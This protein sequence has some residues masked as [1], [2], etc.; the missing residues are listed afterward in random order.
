MKTIALFL[1]LILLLAF[2]SMNVGA[3]SVGFQ[4][5]IMY[6]KGQALEPSVKYILS[7]L[8]L[9]RTIALIAVGLSL[10][11]CGVLLQTILENS[12]AEPYTLG[13]SGGAALGAVVAFIFSTSLGLPLGAFFGAFLVTGIVLF[14]TKLSGSW[15]SNVLILVGVMVSLFCGSLVTILVSVL[16]PSKMQIVLFWMMGQ[17]GS[18]RDTW[19]PYLVLLFAI[20]YLFVFFKRDQLDRLLLGDEQASSLGI[21][22]NKLKIEVIVCVCLLTA[23]SVSI[24]GLIGFVGLVAPHLSYLLLKTRRHRLTLTAAPLVGAAMFLM[25]DVVVR[26]FSRDIEFPSGGVMSL[27]GAPLLVYLL[28]R[29]SRHA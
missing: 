11:L 17:V 19:S 24:A 10:G 28:Y 22:V 2:V 1:A 26:A 16:D 27:M 25:S 5:L 23:F 14:V 4:N 7:D 9:P 13:V 6:L 21:N 8:R 29:K 12:L 15:K 20:I 18:T 3:S